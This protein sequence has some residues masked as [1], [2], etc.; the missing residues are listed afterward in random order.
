MSGRANARVKARVKAR[1]DR[2]RPSGALSGRGSLR[3]F[4]RPDAARVALGSVAALAACAACDASAS[5]RGRPAGRAARPAVVRDAWVRPAGDGAAAYFTLVNAGPDTLV[6][7]GVAT[8]AA[9]G[10]SLHETMTMGQGAGAMVHMA[11]VARLIVPPGDSVMLA[12]GGRHVMLDGLARP[13]APG[14]RVPLVVRLASGDSVRVD[15]EV[16]SPEVHAP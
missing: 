8:P 16:R 9:R 2:R 4:T 12:P 5:D 7:V 13:L 6:A 14:A 10:A 11:P 15:A 3:A 1:A